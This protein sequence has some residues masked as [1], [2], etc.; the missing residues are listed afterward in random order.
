MTPRD[1]PSNWLANTKLSALKS[2]THKLHKRDRA[3]CIYIFLM[4]VCMYICMWSCM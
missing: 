1:E 4:C 2:Y 3:V